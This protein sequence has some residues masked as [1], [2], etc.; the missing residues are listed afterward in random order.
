[1]DLLAQSNCPVL[2]F[3]F[4]VLNGE[5]SDLYEACVEL[6]VEV[7]GRTARMKDTR[8]DIIND[9]L[10]KIGLLNGDGD[11]DRMRGYCRIIVEAAESYSDLILDNFI[12]FKGIV[13][14]LLMCVA[15]DDLEIVKITFNF[16]YIISQELCLPERESQKAVVFN[17]D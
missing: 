12:P 7:I 11:E 2:P 1:V 10:Q 3:V 8:P 13:D 17:R 6:V 15:Y 4:S 5:S 14:A 9:L 16:W